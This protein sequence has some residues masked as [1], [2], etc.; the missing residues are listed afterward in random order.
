MDNDW[1]Y[2]FLHISSTIHIVDF[3]KHHTMRIPHMIHMMHTIQILHIISDI[4]I[5]YMCDV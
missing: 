4:D 1:F 5:V 2:I 3:I